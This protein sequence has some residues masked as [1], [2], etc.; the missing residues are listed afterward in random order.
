M[1]FRSMLTTLSVYIGVSLLGRKKFNLDQMLRRGDYAEGTDKG[2]VPARGWKALIT[3]EFSR[4]DKLMYLLVTGWTLGLFGFFIVVTVIGKIWGL[5]LKFWSSWWHF[6]IYLTLALAI[7]T[8][9]WFSIGGIRDVKKM[10][11][12]L[13][14]QARDDTDDGSVVK[15]DS[16]SEKS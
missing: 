5:S 10:V 11:R 15:S 7:A 14:S 16:E 8:I 4:R 13:L 12:V 9:V 6:Y 2:V 3:P 1:L